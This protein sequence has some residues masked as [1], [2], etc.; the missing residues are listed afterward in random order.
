VCVKAFSIRYEVHWYDLKYPDF[1]N[2]R[3]NNV[4]SAKSQTLIY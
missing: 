2:K 3:E 4:K 1:L